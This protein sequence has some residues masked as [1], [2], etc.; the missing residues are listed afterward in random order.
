[1]NIQ[2][3]TH[4]ATE[5][6]AMRLTYGRISATF[7][8]WELSAQVVYK[9]NRDFLRDRELSA[10]QVVYKNNK[11]GGFLHFCTHTFPVVHL[12]RFFSRAVVFME[13]I[14]S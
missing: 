11:L 2:L 13:N 6:A 1:M 7:C 3:Y 4:R 12:S 9:N 10:A 5:D 14:I 8:D